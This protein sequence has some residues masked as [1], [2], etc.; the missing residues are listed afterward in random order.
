[1]QWGATTGSLGGRLPQPDDPRPDA[2]IFSNSDQQI[3]LL[4]IQYVADIVTVWA[5]GFAKLSILYFYRSIF[6][7]RRTIRTA[8]HS[9]TMCMIVLVSVW[10]VVFGIGLIFI[11]GA[12]PVDA[13]GTLAVVTTECSLQVPIVEGY[14][15]SDFIMDVIIWLLPLPRIWMLNIS[16]RQRMALGLIFL[17]GLLAIAASATRMAIY[18]AHLINPFAQ[19]DGETLVKYLLFWTMIE[20]GLGVIVICLPSL[21]PLY[22]KRELNSLNISFKKYLYR[23]P[24]STTSS[25]IRINS[26]NGSANSKSFNANLVRPWHSGPTT[27][28]AAGRNASMAQPPSNTEQKIHVTREIELTRLGSS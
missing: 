4:Q 16:V 17:V 12:H 27:S 6:C 22:R 11:C 13:W 20:C 5:V 15:I 14:A 28:I 9:V 3:R 21:R 18:I 1:M 19:S 2:Y 8:F 26:L 23:N 10:T 7:S 24:Q 25:A